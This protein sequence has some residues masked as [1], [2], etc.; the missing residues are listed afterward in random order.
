MLMDVPSEKPIRVLLADDHRMILEVFALFLTESG[1]MQVTTA[2][3]FDEAADLIQS[4]GAFD[5]VLLDLH[6]PGMNGV[7]GLRRAIRLNEGKPVAIITGTPTPR[8]QDEIMKAGAS[9]IVL[10]T[11]PVRSLANAIRFMQSGERYLPMELMRLQSPEVRAPRQGHLSD[12][13][14][15]VLNFLAEGKPNKEIAKELQLAEPTVK[16]HVTSIY[17]K[18]DVQNRTQAVVV[19]RDM[20]LV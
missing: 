2:E 7:A 18:F 17:R 13:E 16:M 1:N 4:E 6:M 10:K 15:E 5:V 14:M 3:S 9:G 12:K 20:G 19:A 8:M 11:T